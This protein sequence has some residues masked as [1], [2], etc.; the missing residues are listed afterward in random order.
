[1]PLH[2]GQEEIHVRKINQ[3][4]KIHVGFEF[5]RWIIHRCCFNH[6]AILIRQRNF[7]NI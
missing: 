2:D 6:L 3:S 4:T 7:N 1:M 5:A